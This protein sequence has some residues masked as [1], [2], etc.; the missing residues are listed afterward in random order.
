MQSITDLSM[1][2]AEDIKWRNRNFFQNSDHIYTTGAQP[3]QVTLRQIENVRNGDLRQVLLGFPREKPL[4]A[5]CAHWMH[6]FAGK[7]FFPDANHRTAMLTL[8]YVLD[9]NNVRTPIWPGPDI[10]ET[11]LQSKKHI[12]DQVIVELDTLWEQDAL[13]STWYNHFEQ[14]FQMQNPPLELFR[15]TD[16]D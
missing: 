5:Q 3:E 1:L 10:Q 14:M 9:E 15:E 16:F 7:Q 11:V 4:Y 8:S 13:Y 6:A 2:P 12:R